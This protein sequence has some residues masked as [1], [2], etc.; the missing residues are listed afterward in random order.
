VA[1]PSAGIEPIEVPLL[2]LTDNHATGEI[3][4]PASGEWQLRVTV[5]TSDIDQATVTATVPVR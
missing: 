1:L 2:P 3:S 4:L 5:R